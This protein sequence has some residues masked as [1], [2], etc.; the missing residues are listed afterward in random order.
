MKV[1]R[2]ERATS[3]VDVVGTDERLVYRDAAAQAE[4]LTGAAV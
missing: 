1:I 4:Q 3:A 2:V